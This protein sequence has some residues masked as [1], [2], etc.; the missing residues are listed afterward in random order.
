MPMVS[1]V[2][3]AYHA[4]RY[5]EET[6]RS[7][8]AQTYPDLEIIIV[9]DC[10]TDGTLALARRLA[11]EDSRITVLRN[12][13]NQGVAETRNHGI[14]QAAGTYIALLDSDDVWAPTKL[15]QQL[16]LLAR[17]NADGVYCSYDF[18]D[19][20]GTPMGKPFL[21]PAE[22]SYRK[23][24]AENVIGNSTMLIKSEVMKAHPFN[25]TYYH[26]DYVLWLELL[27]AGCTFCGVQDVL[28]HYRRV[29][30]SRSNNK[31]HAAKK[32]WI[33]YRD[34]LKLSRLQ[35]LWCFAGYAFH[36]VKKYYL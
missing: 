14:R 7:A 10:S 6:V 13:R 24:L 15:E 1:V 2:I 20:S 29:A 18:M 31:V 30:G 9:D 27:Q 8:L 11:E 25:S 34:C 21:V 16:K 36:A 32:R 35:S 28:M 26:E 33:I 5:L 19:E 23:M 4:E 3:P 17:K 12:P 22:T